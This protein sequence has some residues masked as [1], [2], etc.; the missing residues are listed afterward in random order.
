[1]KELVCQAPLTLAHFC[2]VSNLVD[3]EINDDDPE[4][5]WLA[6]S[7]FQGK[8]ADGEERKLSLCCVAWL[9]H[10][11]GEVR[12]PAGKYSLQWSCEE[13]CDE[14]TYRWEAVRFGSTPEQDMR[15]SLFTHSDPTEEL[16]GV[17]EN[18]C[19]RTP[20]FAGY[21]YGF[22]KMWLKSLKIS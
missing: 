16:W 8:T 18:A 13:T 10:N 4:M 17:E 14:E 6:A 22:L 7:Q 11:E 19:T 5:A 15:H 12:Q 3:S 20:L 9:D 1:M 2:L 21:G